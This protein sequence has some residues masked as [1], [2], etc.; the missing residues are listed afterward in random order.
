MDENRVG[1]SICIV[2]RTEKQI[3]TKIFL[4]HSGFVFAL[5]KVSK[6]VGFGKCFLRNLCKKTLLIL[7]RHSSD[8]SGGRGA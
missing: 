8:P 4:S 1:K 3:V 2:Y 6:K 7:L 5:A